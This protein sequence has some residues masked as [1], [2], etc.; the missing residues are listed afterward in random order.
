MHFSLPHRSY[1]LKGMLL[2]CLLYIFSTAVF[3]GNTPLHDI[4][5]SV[6]EVRY[7]A[8]SA[9]FQVS[10]KIFI[11]DFERAMSKEGAP[12][13]HIGGTTE[14]KDAD[15]YIGAYLNNHFSISLDGSRLIPTFVGKELSEDFLAVWCYFEF[16]ARL[17]GVKQCSMF[18]DVLFALYEDQRNIMDIRM[19]SSHK[20][21]TIFQPGKSTWSYTF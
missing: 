8:Q 15:S 11:D 6:C 16:P 19:N 1:G 3:A 10:L 4:H 7:N 18:N 17:T 13:L 2:V 14:I 20:D 5:I 21:Y 12:A 9:S